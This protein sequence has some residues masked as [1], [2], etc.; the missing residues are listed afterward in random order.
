MPNDL[1]LILIGAMVA[2]FLIVLGVTW[3]SEKVSSGNAAIE[4]AI[5]ANRQYR[6]RSMGK[7]DR[8]LMPLMRA[9]I[10]RAS[11][12]DGVNQQYLRWLKQ[13]NWYWAPG[14]SAP[15]TR[16]APY[17]NLE[18]L[19]GEKMIRAATWG[20]IAFITIAVVGVFYFPFVMGL[21]VAP[22]FIAALVLG[23]GL[24]FMG[25]VSPDSAVQGAAASRQRELSL[26]MG[27]RLGELRSD[28]LAGYT[29]QRALRNMGNKPGGPFVEELRRIA[30]VINTTKDEGVA[31]DT[32]MDRN[33]GNELVQE[34]ANQIKMVTREGGEIAPALNVLTEAAQNRLRQQ[35][36]QQGRKN[37]Q[38]MSRPVGMVS[39][40]VTFMLLII[41]AAISIGNMITTFQ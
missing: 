33:S 21:S 9:G 34:F 40:I 4:Q 38:E 3:P 15:P 16:K 2:T 12:N 28:V 11:K 13:A 31:M 41:P 23:A 26:E 18:T 10:R 25:F 37:L 6:S 22:A 17:W 29:I 35:I 39:M 5:D 8:F 1:S 14:E 19:W 27:F 30:A 24:G 36:M 20:G 32:F 7:D